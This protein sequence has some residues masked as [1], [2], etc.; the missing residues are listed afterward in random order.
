MHCAQKTMYA[1]NKKLHKGKAL[2]IDVSQIDVCLSLLL[3]IL[4]GMQRM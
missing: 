3:L 4:E 1:H 2:I